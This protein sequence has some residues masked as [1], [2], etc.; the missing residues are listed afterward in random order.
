M[1]GLPFRVAPARMHERMREADG[2]DTASRQRGAARR[3]RGDGAVSAYLS[4]GSRVRAHARLQ[5]R[6]LR[7]AG[8]ARS[9]VVGPPALQLARVARN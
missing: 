7:R 5:R 9:H 1:S 2:H 8:E 4:T 3:V 6:R